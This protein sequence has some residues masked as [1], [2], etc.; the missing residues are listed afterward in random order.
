MENV[1]KI[2]D[3]WCLTARKAAKSAL[4]MVTGEPG[5]DG[6][7]V[8]RPAGSASSQEAEH[9]LIQSLKMAAVPVQGPLLNRHLVIPHHAKCQFM[10][11]GEPGADGARVQRPVGAVPCSRAVHALIQPL[12]MAAVPVQ[13]PLLSPNPVTLHH[14]RLMVIGP[15][16]ANGAFAQRPAAA[17]TGER[18][19][20]VPIQP[21]T[22]VAWSAKGPASS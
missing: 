1:R 20:H 10:A 7:H 13:D 15:L 6:P 17:V 21:L 3:I 12:R 4:L 11:T 14:A 2:L 5:A 16:G 18:T 22:M 8:Q 9:A 19:E